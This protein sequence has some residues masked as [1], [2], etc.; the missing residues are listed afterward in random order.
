MED[1]GWC[2]KLVVDGK[3]EFVIAIYRQ[4]FLQFLKKKK[5]RMS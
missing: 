5:P 3:H 4:Y 1:Q 2:R